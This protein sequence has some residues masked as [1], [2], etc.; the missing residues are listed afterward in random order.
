MTK[1]QDSR[2]PALIAAQSYDILGDFEKCVLRK[3]IDLVKAPYAMRL[4]PNATFSA[5][6]RDAKDGCGDVTSFS[7]MFNNTD[8]VRRP[9]VDDAGRALLLMA[10]AIL[11]S[12]VCV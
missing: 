10:H 12:A 8:G 11:S 1:D 2:A 6:I 4:P 7:D 3:H 9:T 5:T